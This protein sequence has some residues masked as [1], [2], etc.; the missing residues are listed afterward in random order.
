MQTLA[1]FA[2][3]EVC[4]DYFYSFLITQAAC[5]NLH[6]LLLGVEFVDTL[7]LSVNYSALKLLIPSWSTIGIIMVLWYW[8][9]L[10][11]MPW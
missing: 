1:F 6:L 2:L 3:L 10:Q 11:Y 7:I 9:Y 5:M 8:Y 4:N